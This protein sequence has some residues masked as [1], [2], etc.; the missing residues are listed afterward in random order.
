MAK[1]RAVPFIS[2]ISLT[3]GRIVRG[4]SEYLKEKKDEVVAS[5]EIAYG[6]D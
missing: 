3:A 2:S 4:F 6:V 1:V 5:S